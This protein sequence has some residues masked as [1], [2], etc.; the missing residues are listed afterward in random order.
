MNGKSTEHAMEGRGRRR[1]RG[2]IRREGKG[3]DGEGHWSECDEE[4]CGEVESVF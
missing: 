1:R 4:L 2:E 3:W